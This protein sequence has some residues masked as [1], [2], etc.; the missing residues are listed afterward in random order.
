M[1]LCTKLF[2]IPTSVCIKIQQIHKCQC[3]LGE[4]YGGN[5]SI[6]AFKYKCWQL[7][8]ICSRLTPTQPQQSAYQSV[9]WRAVTVPIFHCCSIDVLANV[10]FFSPSVSWL[11]FVAFFSDVPSTCVYLSVQATL[12]DVYLH[13]ATFFA[14]LYK[15][16]CMC[17]CMQ[18]P[19]IC[20]IL[21]CC[22][23]WICCFIWNA[24]L[25]CFKMNSLVLWQTVCI[26]KKFIYLI[27]AIKMIWLNRKLWNIWF[28]CKSCKICKICKHISSV[29][30]LQKSSVFCIV[31][32]HNVALAWAYNMYLA[33]LY[34]YTFKIIFFFILLDVF[35]FNHQKH[36]LCFLNE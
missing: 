19:R 4:G 18:Q 6:Q 26:Y 22:S 7:D 35:F 32:W 33:E 36:I 8:M 34:L 25:V 16:E 27:M 24:I 1:C 9:Y 3:R 29:Y 14:N 30:Y 15:H 13:A 11:K 5:N 21:N 31:Y 2:Y 23:L 20:F 17:V 12:A 10:F 28:A